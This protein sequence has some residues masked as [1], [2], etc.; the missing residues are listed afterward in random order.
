MVPS[1]PTLSSLTVSCQ[2]R[3]SYYLPFLSDA[4]QPI[5]LSLK[6]HLVHIHHQTFLHF[7]SENTVGALKSL[8]TKTYIP[9]LVFKDPI[10]FRVTSLSTHPP[11]LQTSFPNTPHLCHNHSCAYVLCSGMMAPA[12]S[13][14]PDC[15]NPIHLMDPLFWQ[16]FFSIPTELGERPNTQILPAMVV[17]SY[18]SRHHLHFY[19][20]P[21]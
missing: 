12:T 17:F 7:S 13:Q 2:I 5:S 15:S 16:C 14:I 6:T 9:Y 3:L 18:L 10:C 4:N 11:K 1:C 21:W 8:S 19:M 20:C